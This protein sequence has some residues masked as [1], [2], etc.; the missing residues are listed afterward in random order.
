MPSGSRSSGLFRKSGGMPV[1]RA[2]HRTGLQDLCSPEARDPRSLSRESL[3]VKP[4]RRDLIL[5]AVD[6]EEGA[7][8]MLCPGCRS[9]AGSFDPRFDA[10]DEYVST[11]SLRLAVERAAERTQPGAPAASRQQQIA[12]AAGLGRMVISGVAHHVTW[13]ASSIG[14]A[15]DS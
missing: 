5:N 11:R 7:P 13:A 4:A 9:R 8:T 12:L 1:A 2:R 3:G 15:A 10:P 6:R 14:R